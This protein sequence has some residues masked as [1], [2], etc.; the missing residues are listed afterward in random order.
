MAEREGEAWLQAR[1]QDPGIMTWAEGRHLT[2]WVTQALIYFN[3]VS[4]EDRTLNLIG[5]NVYFC[6]IFIIYLFLFIYSWETQRER[7]RHRQK[8][9]Q[10]SHREPDAGLDPRTLGSR[11]E[12]KVDAQ[13]LSYPGA[14]N[15]YFFKL[16]LVWWTFEELALRPYNLLNW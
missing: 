16:D 1:F 9:K 11:P 13:P 6:I 14:P 3:F 8:E 4:Q 5:S 10:A 7:Q 12:P 15:V 2:D